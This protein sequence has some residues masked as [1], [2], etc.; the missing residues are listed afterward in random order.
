ML[1][2]GLV[3]LSDQMALERSVDVIA[4]NIANSSTVG[5]K[6]EG[7]QFDTLLTPTPGANATLPGQRGINFVYDRATYRDTTPG[8]I[9]N[10]GNPL[11]LAIQGSGYFKIQTAQ[12]TRY[13]RDGAFCTDNQGN[14]VT[15]TG[16]MVLSD[17]GQP[18]TIPDGASNITVSGEG[19]VSV[20]VGTVTSRTNLG[21]IAVVKFADEQQMSPAGN[22]LY[23]TTQQETPV[24]GMPIVEGALEQSNVKPV[25]EITDLIKIQRAYEQATNL[26]SQQN[27]RLDN[28]ID[29]LS[30]TS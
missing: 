29:K 23:A 28:A 2:T 20:Q 5:F 19:D 21:K 4:N 6:R 22:G 3:L 24:T 13:T 10:T 17:G 11:D 25:V 1:V 12:G 30:A 27:Q 7:I 9:T 15:S 16:K 14:L 8:T 18:I 26:I